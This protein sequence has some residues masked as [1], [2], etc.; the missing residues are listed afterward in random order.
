M[1]TLPVI[2]AL[3]LGLAATA[4]AAGSNILFAGARYH[5]DPVTTPELPYEQGDL[6]AVLGF[7]FYQGAMTRWQLLAAYTPDPSNQTVDY[8]ITPQ[9][10]FLMYEQGFLLGAG[11]L[12]SYLPLN[13]DAVPAGADENRD[14]WTDPYYQ[15]LAG[16]TYPVGK[17]KLTVMAAFPFEEFDQIQDFEFDQLEYMAGLSFRF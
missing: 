6:S 3:S 1:K 2:L 13:D 10:N 9:L 5:A 14:D 15:L 7:D 16:F 8:A 12:M 17:A 11:V 4:S